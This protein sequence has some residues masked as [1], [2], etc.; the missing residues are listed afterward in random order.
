MPEQSGA[1]YQYFV[2]IKSPWGIGTG[3]RLGGLTRLGGIT[4][5]L[6]VNVVDFGALGDGLSDDFPAIQRA[7]DF[8]NE[9]SMS[10][11]VF[12]RGTYIINSTLNLYS[13][14]TLYGPESKPTIKAGAAMTNMVQA[15]DAALVNCGFINLKFDGDSVATTAIAPASAANY[16]STAYYK[17]IT[18]TNCTGTGIITGLG[19]ALG[20]G[21]A[22]AVAIV[23]MSDI[24]ISA[25]GNGLEIDIQKSYIDRLVL[26]N[27]GSGV[28]PGVGL[29]ITRAD[30][31]EIRT[32]INTLNGATDIG[33]RVGNGSGGDNA[34]GLRR[35]L[36][37]I[38][39]VDNTSGI[40]FDADMPMSQN[41]IIVTGITTASVN[42]IK[43]NPA[44]GKTIQKNFFRINFD[45]STNSVV[46]FSGAGTET[47]NLFNVLSPDATTLYTGT[48]GTG[49][50]VYDMLNVTYKTKFAMKSADQSVN[51]TVTMANTTSLSFAAGANEAWLVTLGVLYTT[52]STAGIRWDFNIPANAVMRWQ[53]SSASGGSSTPTSDSGGSSSP[54]SSSGGAATPTS[55]AGSSHTHTVSGQTDSDGT[56]HDHVTF[57]Y[58]SAASWSDPT[59]SILLQ[60]PE[61]VTFTQIRVGRDTD[62][63]SGSLHT[64]TADR[65]HYHGV[66]GVATAGE[67]THTHTVT[68]SNHTHTVTISAHTHTVTIS[69]HMHNQTAKTEGQVDNLTGAATSAWVTFFGIM[70]TGA[71]AGTIQHRFAQNAADASD[72]TIHQYSWIKAEKLAT[73]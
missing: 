13:N 46:A 67:A 51:N 18:V 22:D 25:C 6:Y 31:C 38:T 15:G 65:T 71:T 36:V 59:Y 72:T 26:T 21:D 23:N 27:I 17:D 60:A 66:L 49:T 56:E 61:G 34:T 12:P 43:I 8:A 35:S 10:M 73:L 7:I 11:I 29:I 63:G 5:D 33:V 2:D 44:A 9:N 1:S 42:P 20:G 55:S 68:I 16:F 70:V 69:A 3:D 45:C 39:F 19:T 32:I 30:N 50:V 14:I 48:P 58:V 64:G 41:Q 54:T 40:T 53:T 28:D 47:N 4:A 52:N 62:P 57:N 37:H 24:D